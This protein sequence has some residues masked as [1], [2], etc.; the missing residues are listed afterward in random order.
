[1]I[2]FFIKIKTEL[3]KLEKEQWIL[4][5]IVL[6]GLLLRLWGIDFGLPNITY[7]DEDKLGNFAIENSYRI[8]N[9]TR[10]GSFSALSPDDFIYGTFSIYLNFFFILIYKIF[11]KLVGRDIDIY[12]SYVTLRLSN[13]LL[14]YLLSMLIPL[15]YLKIFKDKLG[16]MFTVLFVAL[17]WKLVVHSH[18]LNADIM[19]TVLL[20]A[21]LFFLY[22]FL[23]DSKFNLR[24]LVLSGIFFGFSVGTKITALISLPLFLLILYKKVPYEKVL[25][26]ATFVFLAYALS[27]PF[28]FKEP[29]RF[30]SRV[31]EMR[32]KENGIVLDS[33]DFSPFKYVS[34]LSFIVTPLIFLLS[35]G[36]IIRVLLR[37]KENS[38]FYFHL[39]LIA[40]ILVYFY[41]F[42]FSTRRVDRWMLPVIPILFLYGSYFISFL[43]KYLPKAQLLLRL[44]MYIFLILAF[45]NYPVFA[46]AIS[47]QLG[48]VTPQI[49][50]FNWAKKNI[51]NQNP[52]LLITDS[53][54]DPIRSVS[55]I[56]VMKVLVYS[57]Q[58]AV[59]QVLYDPKMYEYVVIMSRPFERYRNVTLKELYPNY[60][61]AWKKY[62]ETITDS[63]DFTLVKS[64]KVL[65]PNLVPLSSAYIYKNIN[66]IPVPVNETSTVN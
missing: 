10:T 43:I 39:F 20:F 36:G 35:L 45:L 5:L 12:G 33:V 21:S 37:H 54:L 9:I 52:K 44:Y 1:M 49:E 22:R 13:A 18:Y 58:G 60:Y 26:F 8:K 65:E 25:F 34:A 15:L 50:A 42:T 46:F 64:F 24:F 61:L 6:I 2:S 40:N 63:K 48:R 27:N 32:L 31:N 51:K 30:I 59:N 38:D 55:G 17:N 29:E 57:S 3:M 66:F 4:A 16:F 47:N 11:T 14:T 23:H 62:D 7:A 19:L 41:F 56:K 28:A 53:S